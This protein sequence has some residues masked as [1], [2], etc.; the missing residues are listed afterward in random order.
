MLRKAEGLQS[1]RRGDPHELLCSTVGIVRCHV[2]IDDDGSVTSCQ[3]HSSDFMSPGRPDSNFALFRLHGDIVTKS[4]GPSIGCL[5]LR[6][7]SKASMRKFRFSRRGRIL[8]RS[9]CP[10]PSIPS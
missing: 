8:G 6:K 9:P 10:E 5:S 7:A 2:E 1:S 4:N 3:V